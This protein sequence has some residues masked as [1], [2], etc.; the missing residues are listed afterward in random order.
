MNKQHFHE[1]LEMVY[2]D[3]HSAIIGGSVM[4]NLRDL[5]ARAPNDVDIIIPEH[6]SFTKFLIELPEINAGHT[7]ESTLSST[8]T[9]VFGNRIQRIACQ[10]KDIKICVFK[11]PVEQLIYDTALVELTYIDAIDVRIQKPMFAIEAKRQYVKDHYLKKTLSNPYMLK[12]IQDLRDI[13]LSMG[14]SD[15]DALLK[16]CFSSLYEPPF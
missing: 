5:I 15:E 1:L 2:R 16:E 8:C 4:L 9:D 7:G 13:A 6:L 10:Y 12:H 11:V 3:M 14:L